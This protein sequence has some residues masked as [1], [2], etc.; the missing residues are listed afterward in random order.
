M[1]SSGSVKLRYEKCLGFWG[2][3]RFAFSQSLTFSAFSVAGMSSSLLFI[4]VV[5]AKVSERLFQ[6]DKSSY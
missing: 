3:A 2:N 4:S 1:S 5:I 6:T